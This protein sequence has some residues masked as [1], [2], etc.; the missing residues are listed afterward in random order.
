MSSSNDPIL[1][2]TEP[3]FGP[4]VKTNIKKFIEKVDNLIQQLHNKKIGLTFTS[5]YSPL[6]PGDIRRLLVESKSVSGVELILRNMLVNSAFAAY[7]I[8]PATDL[9]TV[10]ATKSLLSRALKIENFTK[11]YEASLSRDLSR[12]LSKNAKLTGTDRLHGFLYHFIGDPMAI[13]MALDSTKLAGAG[14]SVFIEN[15]KS[16]QDLVE[17][18]LGY[19][20]PVSPVPEF[21][22]VTQNQKWSG[23]NVKVLVIDGLIERV[24]EINHCLE[25]CSEREQAL[26]ILARGFAEEVI[27]TLSVNFS[28]KTLSVIPIIVAFDLDGANMLKDIAVVS[29][30][31]PVSSLKGELISSIEFDDICTVNELKITNNELTIFN[32]KTLQ[33]VKKLKMELIKKRDEDPIIFGE[34][35]EAQKTVTNIINRRLSSLSSSC[36]KIKIS[37]SHNDNYGIFQDRIE[38]C[39][40]LIKKT[41]KCGL[42]SVDDVFLDI[43]SMKD[44]DTDCLVILDIINDLKKFG[45]KDYPSI[46]L[47]EGIKMGRLNVKNYLSIAGFLIAS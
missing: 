34:D 36:T 29:G 8:S 19:T 40:Q 27:A 1:Q 14:G 26:I 28:R 44:K 43:K 31:D 24:S 35:D 22:M 16:E 17:L 42:T 47:A 7:K 3:V 18:S 9:V 5:R 2:C 12:I 10:L 21:T 37:D 13:N 20:F 23:S 32:S 30:T 15:E 33:Q 41:A 46:A 45:F 6:G 38:S 11:T 39:I 4:S 25:A